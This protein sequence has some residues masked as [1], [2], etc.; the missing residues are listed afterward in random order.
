[1]SF[2][3]S[4]PWQNFFPDT[5]QISTDSCRIPRHFRVF[6]TCGYHGYYFGEWRRSF[7]N[8]G[9]RRSPRLHHWWGPVTTPFWPIAL[10]LLL[11]TRSEKNK[12]GYDSFPYLPCS[13]LPSLP[14]RL[15]PSSSVFFVPSLPSYTVSGGTLNPT[16]SLTHSLTLLLY[17]PPLR[18]R[19]LKSS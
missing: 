3:S 18:S 4:F 10:R 7:P 5:S 2:W 6:E 13:S 14:F 9:K 17:P 16:H 15:P 8:L 1:M 19:T 11:R 12:W